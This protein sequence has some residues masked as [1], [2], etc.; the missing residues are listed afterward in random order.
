MIRRKMV[1]E[2][3][4]S[5]AG[6]LLIASPGMDDKRFQKAV[7]Y[8][9]RH[10]ESDGA[11]G[12]VINRPTN[13]MTLHGI[14]AQLNIPV[15]D[16]L[17]PEPPILIGGPCD[18]HHGFV[19]HSTEYSTPGT[20]PVSDDISLTATQSILKDIARLGGPKDFLIALGCATW[21]KGQ[22]EEELMGNFWMTA[23]ASPDVIFV[24]APQDKWA[25][26]LA[27]I[28]VN[29]AVLSDKFGKS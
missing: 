17:L 10:T 27:S 12:I 2:T 13:Q 3:P 28:G 25:G 9:S 29:P 23:P 21:E 24:Q 22:L 1:K 7:V 19:L 15:P 5:L 18:A 16:A 6:Q 11:M 26:A 14:F 8:L 20:M 4:L